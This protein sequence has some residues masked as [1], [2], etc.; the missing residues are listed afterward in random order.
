M[1]L[2]IG[3][4]SR[5]LGRRLQMCLRIPTVIADLQLF[6]DG[7][8]CCRA[9]LENNCEPIV[10]LHGTHPH[11]DQNL[12]QLY[13]LIDIAVRQGPSEVVCVV[14]YLAYA[15]QDRRDIGNAP[16]SAGIVLKTLEALGATK[17]V[18]IDV[19]NEEIF[20]AITIDAVNLSPADPM[21]HW[22][23]TR[24][25]SDP[26]LISPDVGG[27]RRVSAVA[28][29]LGWDYLICRKCKD[30]TGY[31]WY[32]KI[33]RDLRGRDA[34]IIDDLCSSGSTLVP[35]AEALIQS[36]VSK[37]LIGVTHF[38]ADAASVQNKIGYD[39]D[40]FSTNT[41]PSQTAKIDLAP[42]IADHLKQCLNLS[43]SRLVL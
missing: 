28:D 42:L 14:P 29:R 41:I 6:P 32:N 15:R 20:D 37:I 27:R 18:T 5:E 1:H 34:V 10:L 23:S 17:F 16:F 11:Q 30:E 31:T 35:L 3:P 39:V 2:V 8:S 22:L 33:T 9:D 26:I 25:L 7:E 43:N 21:A 19:H 36:G 12:Q 13:Q 40:I 4:S 24:T 38:F